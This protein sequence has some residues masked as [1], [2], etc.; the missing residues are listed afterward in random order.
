MNVN[1]LTENVKMTKSGVMIL[2]LAL[3]TAA[4]GA[5]DSTAYPM[6]G[7][8]GFATLPRPWRVRPCP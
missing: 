2:L 5:V 7:P 6:T 8:T 1:T 4:F 3:A